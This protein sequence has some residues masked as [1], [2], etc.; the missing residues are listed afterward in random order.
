MVAY[1]KR[2][3]S[4][5]RVPK[6]LKLDQELEKKRVDIVR[7]FSV[8]RNLYAGGSEVHPSKESE[9]KAGAE[10]LEVCQNVRKLLSFS[11]RVYRIYTWTLYLMS[12]DSIFR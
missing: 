6:S 11:Y 8:A 9:L 1:Q 3:N 10:F 5:T 2:L 7:S 12:Y 4:S